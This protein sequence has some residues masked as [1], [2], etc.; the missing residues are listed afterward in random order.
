VA[1]PK[2]PFQLFA[3]EGAAEKQTQS[4][5]RQGV[6]DFIFENAILRA[7]GNNAMVVAPMPE[8]ALYLHIAELLARFEIAMLRDPTSPDTAR[9]HLQ[10]DAAIFDA[11]SVFEDAYTLPWRREP[12][13]CT[14]LTMPVENGVR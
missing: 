10:D 4:P 9:P 6:V 1:V 12:F 5:E 13:E 3:N 8:R 14:R 7:I 11:S 2:H